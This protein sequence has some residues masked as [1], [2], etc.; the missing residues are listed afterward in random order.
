[1]TA[2]STELMIANRALLL[3]GDMQ[4]TQAQLTAS[5]VKAARLFNQHYTDIILEV[6]GKTDWGF[7]RKTKPLVLVYDPD[8]LEAVDISA[9][10]QADPCQIT[11]TAHG[12][13][14]GDYCYIEDV[15]G[16]TELNGRRYI[17]TRIDDD[18][19]TLDDV[20]ASAYTAYGSGGSLSRVAPLSDYDDGYMYE[21]PSDYHKALKLEGDYNYELLG[22][23]LYTNEKWP[24]LRYTYEATDIADG[25]SSQFVTAVVARMAAELAWPLTKKRTLMNDMWDRYTRLF[26]ESAGDNAQYEPA[27]VE[28]ESSWLNARS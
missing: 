21:L 18:T 10:T 12:L 3:L 15:T 8:E 1:M 14:T 11:A 22:G 7:A 19:L 6:L 4:L 16:M 28:F 17:V 2:S 9:A 20:D 26:H 27:Q 23:H 25:W 5:S 24:V 13:A